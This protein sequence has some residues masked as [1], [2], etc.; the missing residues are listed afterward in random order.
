VSGLIAVDWGTSSLRLALLGA[1]GAVLEERALPRGILSV[2]PG[3]F[4][5]T[6]IAASADWVRLGARFGLI[7]GMAG[8]RQGWIEAPY[9]AC[10]AG[11]AEVAARLAWI[12]PAPMDLRLAIVPGL[13]CETAG[14]PDVMRGE[15]VQV[16]GAMELLGLADARLVLPGTHSKWVE[17][18]NGRIEGFSTFMTGE[19]YALLRQHSILSRTLPAEDGPLDEA[20]F[21]RGVEHAHAA[22]N[23]LHAAFSART[24]SLFERLEAAALPS[25]LSGLV[26]G[27]ELRSQP[28]AAGTDVIAIG[29]PALTARYRLALART[30]A[31]VHAVGSEATWRGLWAIAR[32]VENA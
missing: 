28:I 12:D 3:E 18:R 10:P 1:Q 21:L 22:G 25:Y 8:S 29:A 5:T 2:A 16:F 9:C 23:L 27:E 17:L 14:V 20:A 13:S 19:F 26:I 6:F 32:T 4:A 15:E 31:R 11:F 7:S 24:L 30:G